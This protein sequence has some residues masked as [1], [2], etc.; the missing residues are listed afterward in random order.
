[1]LFES[2]WPG[3][4]I[5]A[6][7]LLTDDPEDEISTGLRDRMRS[8]S[9]LG[10]N[11]SGEVPDRRDLVKSPHRR[12][13]ISLLT[14]LLGGL[15]SRIHRRRESRRVNVAWAMVDDRTLNDIGTSRLEVEYAMDAR[16]W[17]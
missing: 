6:P 2:E 10:R 1:M 8:S 3:D 13:W 5:A 15:R 12:R 17:G 9:D 7:I 16:H 4:V 11:Q 14:S